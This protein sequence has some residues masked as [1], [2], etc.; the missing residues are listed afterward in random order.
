MNEN[1]FS[2]AFLNTKK[3]T[4]KQQQ[5]SSKFNSAALIKNFVNLGEFKMNICLAKLWIKFIILQ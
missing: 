4:K 1:N 5:I 2:R 3:H